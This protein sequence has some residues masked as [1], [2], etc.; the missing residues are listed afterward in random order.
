MKYSEAILKGCEM[1][2]NQTFHVLCRMGPTGEILATCA[3]GAAAQG[4]G[5]ARRVKQLER[6]SEELEFQLHADTGLLHLECPALGSCMWMPGRMGTSL[7]V[8]LNDAHRWSR[9]R[10]AAFLAERGL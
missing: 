5:G 1:T 4:L 9:E 7:I 2:P 8:H 6:D 3:R 10:I